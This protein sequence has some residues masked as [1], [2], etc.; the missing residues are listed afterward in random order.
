MTT[1]EK[2]RVELFRNEGKSY[3]VIAAELGMSENTIKSY[4]RR[5]KIN[6]TSTQINTTGVCT[7]CN[8]PITHTKG[9]K[10]KRFCSDA[11]RMAWWKSHPEVI[12]R[13]AVYQFICLSCG[14]SFESYGN[15]SRKYCSRACYGL[16]KRAES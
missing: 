2:Q 16:S 8:S 1:T 4:C 15:A 7:Q 11:C 6:T 3:S 13:K 10:K 12:S 9:S 14:A 5:N